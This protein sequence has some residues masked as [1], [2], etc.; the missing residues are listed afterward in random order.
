MPMRASRPIRPR[1]SRLQL[2]LWLASGQ[3]ALSSCSAQP[4][5]VYGDRHY[6]ALPANTSV[7]VFMRESDIHQ[8]YEVLGAVT[9]MDL[10]KYQMLGLQD[11]FPTL[12]QKALAV[13]GNGLIIDSYQPVKSGILSTGYS[14]QA[15]A[16]RLQ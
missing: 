16:I 4:P 14:V 10:G 6:A 2:V 15:R 11:A 1:H 12:K 13:G 9:A 8:R 7:Q 5:I 3:L